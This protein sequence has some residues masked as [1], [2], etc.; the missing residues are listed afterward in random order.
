MRRG[1]CCASSSNTGTARLP[2]R[3]RS[4]GVS[5]AEL[6][7]RTGIRLRDVAVATAAG[8]VD[9]QND[10]RAGLKRQK[11]LEALLEIPEFLEPDGGPR[12]PIEA[13]AWRQMGPFSR[14]HETN[15]AGLWNAATLNTALERKLR[16]LFQCVDTH[17]SPQ[18]LN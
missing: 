1:R 11:K 13:K 15:E 6:A 8:Q 2:F 18:N 17:R 5:L 9:G 4:P 7:E 10:A 3:V 16:T 14:A 12:V